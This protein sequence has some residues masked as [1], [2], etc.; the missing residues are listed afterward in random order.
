MTDEDIGGYVFIHYAEPVF[1]N[2]TI[3][4]NSS[5]TDIGIHLQGSSSLIITN[6]I[7]RNDLQNQKSNQSALDIIES[8]FT[9]L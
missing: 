8:I 7:I 9:S 5:S 4:E 3:V 2:C 6:C 1:T